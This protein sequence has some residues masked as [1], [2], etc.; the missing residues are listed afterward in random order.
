MTTSE[1]TLCV[2]TNGLNSGKE[3]IVQR[4]WRF[5]RSERNHSTATGKEHTVGRMTTLNPENSDRKGSFGDALG[6]FQAL[7]THC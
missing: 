4:K 1:Y 2:F 6:R 7:R 5:Q 3:S